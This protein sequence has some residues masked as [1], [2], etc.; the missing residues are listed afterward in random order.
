MKHDPRF[1]SRARL[2]HLEALADQRSLASHEIGQRRQNLRLER[3]RLARRRD[4]LDDGPS[5]GRNL[6]EGE[7]KRLN[8]QIEAIDLDLADLDDRYQRLGQ[9]HQQARTTYIRAKARAKELGLPIPNDASGDPYAGEP[10]RFEP[11]VE[12]PNGGTQE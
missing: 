1:D 2:A 7:V 12:A 11:E 6:N 5:F 10:T 4:D 8:E 3:Q 9:E